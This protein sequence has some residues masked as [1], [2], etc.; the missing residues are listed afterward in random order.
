MTDFKV[1]AVHTQHTPTPRYCLKVLL[2]K[3]V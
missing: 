1:Q 3:E 2:I